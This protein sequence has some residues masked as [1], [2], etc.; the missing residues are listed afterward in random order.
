MS[1]KDSQSNVGADQDQEFQR[2]VPE[3]PPKR[4]EVWRIVEVVVEGNGG[5]CKQTK[6]VDDVG[7]GPRGPGRENR[8]KLVSD[9]ST[10]WVAGGGHHHRAGGGT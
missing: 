6:V 4:G 9:P 2:N 1:P 10:R 8:R 7:G 3:I 5:G